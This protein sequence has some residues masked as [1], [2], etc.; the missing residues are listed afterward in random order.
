MD[1]NSVLIAALDSYSLDL[2]D[3]FGGDI[4]DA[5]DNAISKCKDYLSHNTVTTDW[6]KRNWAIMSPAVKA[7]RKYLVDDIH[8]ARIIEDKETL[9]KLQAEY[10]ILSPY[11]ELFKTFPNFLH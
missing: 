5:I 7:H 3:H 9:E 1:A 6:V 11:I 2:R 8:H 10:Y 4:A